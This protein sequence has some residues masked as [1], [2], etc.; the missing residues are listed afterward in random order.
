LK[1]PFK[2]R[3][4]KRYIVLVIICM[5]VILLNSCL[6]SRTSDKK[7][8]KEFEEAGV[9]VKIDYFQTS[10]HAKKVRVVTTGMEKDTT[11]LF[12]HGAPGS[13][14]A[15][16]SYLKDSVLLERAKLISIDRPG[17]GYS[18]FGKSLTSIEA[19]AQV[20]REICDAYNLKNIILVGHSFG[21][22]IAAYV[23]TISDKIDGVV[24]LAPAIDPDNEKIFWIANFAR[25]KITKWMVPRSLAVAGDE[26]FSHSEEL[27]KIRDA[28]GDVKI[29]VV[30]IH[31]EK[32]AIVPYANL[33]FATKEFDDTYYRSISLPE[34][35]HFIPWTQKPLVLEE[36][37]GLLN[38]K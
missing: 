9:A 14:D 25:W 36:I 21:G 10:S 18:D 1:L 4:R 20:V 7:T 30:H 32:D 15:F 11:I 23:P 31:G 8:L 19:Q 13:S 34:E 24:M 38:T 37:L 26:K 35:N 6:K 3:F 29:P 5:P 17:Y 22:P 12:I 2:F 28:W 16:Y 27:R 33:A